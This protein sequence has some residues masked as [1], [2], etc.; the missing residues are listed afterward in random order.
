MK[1]KPPKL[2]EKAREFRRRMDLFEQHKEM[3][4]DMRTT[5]LTVLAT[6]CAYCRYPPRVHVDGKCL[7]NH[8][9]FRSL[10]EAPARV[11][12][13]AYYSPYLTERP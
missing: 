8:T 4:E 13:D 10:G 1:P 3:G 2:E 6:S 11:L 9:M 12:L 7:F 5:L